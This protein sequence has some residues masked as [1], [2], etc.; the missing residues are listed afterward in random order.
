MCEDNTSA[1][2]L[3]TKHRIT[4]RTRHYHTYA[5]FFWE[6]ISNPEQ[7]ID[8]FYIHTA[9]Q[10]DDYLTKGL[11]SEQFKAIRLLVQGW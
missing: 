10:Q 5:H 3:A 8:I 6:I 9:A 1:L 2:T 4:S 11:L 7:A